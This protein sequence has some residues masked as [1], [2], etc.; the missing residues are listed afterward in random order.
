MLSCS[1]TDYIGSHTQNAGSHICK[2]SPTFSVETKVRARN[3][4]SDLDIC[5]TQIFNLVVSN[6]QFNIKNNI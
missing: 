6:L 2:K 1:S 5:T 4:A 3:Y